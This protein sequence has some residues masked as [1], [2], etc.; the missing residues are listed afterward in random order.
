M[1]VS[2][3]ESIIDYDGNGLTTTFPVPFKFQNNGDLVVALVDSLGTSTTLAM[4]TDYTVIGAGAQS[5]G[6]IIT[7]VAPTSSQTIGI[8]RELAPVQSTDLRN[9]GRFFA[10]THE[11][12]FDYITMLIQ[13]S[14]SFL[15]RALVRPVGKAYYD[16][17]G[18]QIRSLGSAGG[19]GSNATNYDDLREAIS[20]LP[21]P[22]LPINYVST[23]T[24]IKNLMLVT[25]RADN[26]QYDVREYIVGTGRGGGR[27]TWSPST[28]KSKHNGGTVF[29]PTVPFDGTQASLA[30]FLLGTGETSPTGNGCWVRIYDDLFGE[31]FG[32]CGGAYRD[33]DAFSAAHKFAA[34]NYIP[35]HLNGQYYV[36]G[37]QVMGGRMMLVGHNGASLTG[38]LKYLCLTFPPAADTTTPITD[39]APYFDSRGMAWKAIDGDAGLEVQAQYGDKFIDTCNVN[40]NKFYGQVGFKGTHLIGGVMSDNDFYTTIAGVVQEGCTNW[41]YSELRFRQAARFGVVLR[42]NTLNPGRKGGENHKFSLCEW[43]VCT[44]GLRQIR[45]QWC[46]VDNSL[47]DYCGLPVWATGCLYQK[48]SDTYFGAAKQGSLESM[49]GY[50]APPT[51][52][53]AFYSEPYM[54]GTVAGGDAV[55]EPHSWTAD[56]CEYVNYT[57]G[58]TQPLVNSTGYNSDQPTGNFSQ[59]VQ[60]SKCKLIAGANHAASQLMAISYCTDVDLDGIIFDSYNKSTT[61]TDPFI[62]NNVTTYNVRGTDTYACYQ[63]GLRMFSKFERES[64]GRLAMVDDSLGLLLQNT[65]GSNCLVVRGSGNDR[66]D[67]Y[68][69]GSLRALGVGT[70]NSGGTGYRTVVVPN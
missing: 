26:V 48:Y 32:M 29:S 41:T 50:V 49:P 3:T 24:S 8:S 11:N 63:S 15:G 28:P 54:S 38:N 23:A 9:Q 13:Q 62:L 40:K 22:G 4:G 52:G 31:Y 12:V 65:S 61:M 16:A 69:G 30:A 59:K 46:T 68:L 44:V 7:L 43:A 70:A 2:T 5:G 36:A 67:L 57:S 34:A 56:G 6:A 17:E 66:V 60:M 19:V 42:P 58:V 64:L 33:P 25:P 37:A 39:T 27:F 35:L 18:R 47:F 20:S 55:V 45:T 10:E 1:T 14:F 21:G 53:T 51:V